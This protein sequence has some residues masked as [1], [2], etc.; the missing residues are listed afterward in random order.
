MAQTQKLDLERFLYWQGQALR[1][2]DLNDGESYDAE[3]RWWHN[4]A[5]HNVY[6]VSQGLAVSLPAAF[7]TG[8]AVSVDSG[9]AYDCY[10]RELLLK[11]RE[12]TPIAKT[13]PSP[14]VSSLLLVLR[15]RTT[16]N[17]SCAPAAD[18]WPGGVHAL[19]VEFLWIDPRQWRVADGVPLAKFDYTGGGPVFD[20]SFVVPRA[21][22][23]AGPIVASGF[24]LPGHTPWQAWTDAP[25]SGSTSVGPGTGFALQT[26]VDTSPAG[27]SQAPCYFA[28]LQG[29]VW[30]GRRQLVLPLMC[31]SICD[32]TI[33]SFSFRIWF[34]ELGTLAQGRGKTAE[35]IDDPTSFVRF[36]REQS[37]YVWWIGC[38]MPRPMPFVPPG[39]GR[40]SCTLL[41]LLQQ[42]SLTK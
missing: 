17:C 38:Q 10:G 11:K 1:S 12:W 2:R 32:E 9:L 24:T 23:V 14:S 16:E 28:W 41:E 6:G 7:G 3:R 20:S 4:R 42:T 27:F 21:M 25:I 40:C 37:L 31:P 18:C 15:A 26:I 33:D 39:A 34:P 5:V 35:F 36:A 13:P 19:A 30:D 29:P 8:I 22:P